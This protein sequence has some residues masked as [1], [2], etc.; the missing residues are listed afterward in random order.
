M[1]QIN[2]NFEE[3]SLKD[4]FNNIKQQLESKDND[5]MK[6]RDLT[7][8]IASKQKTENSD[9]PLD[10]QT[11]RLNMDDYAKNKIFTKEEVEGTK[12]TIRQLEA[13]FIEKVNHD[14]IYDKVKQEINGEKVELLT[15]VVLYK[16]LKDKFIVTRSARYDDVD[17]GVDT[18]IFNKDSG[19]IVCTLDESGVLFGQYA[20][21]K[22][23]KIFE[24]NAKGGARLKYGLIL[25]KDPEGK[26]HIQGGSVAN[27]PIF[28]I[29]VDSNELNKH[30]P[31]VQ[32]NLENISDFERTLFTYF[33]QTIDLQVIKMQDQESNIPS[34]I[35]QSAKDFISEIQ[36]LFPNI[37][38]Y[39]NPVEQRKKGILKPEF[40]TLSRGVSN[41]KERDT[42][43]EKI[44]F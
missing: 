30:L 29:L 37:L 34:N 8:I 44:S 26:N 27:I 4:E 23:L 20:D 10:I 28:D 39:D 19:K 21:K 14:N 33:A 38:Y 18:V 17:N 22:R 32:N 13:K 24:K 41:N 35:K 36:N 1:E 6:L 12:D 9:L 5:L 42:F 16:F 40:Y 25:T 7:S 43:R 31:E 2:N 3:T 11:S 15:S